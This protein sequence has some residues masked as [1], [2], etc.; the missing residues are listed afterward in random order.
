MTTGVYI[1][2]KNSVASACWPMEKA[3]NPG[4]R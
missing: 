3:S 4:A 1:I 2:R